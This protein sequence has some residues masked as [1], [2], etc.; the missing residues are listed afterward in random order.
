MKNKIE[1]ETDAV[2]SD[3]QRLQKPLVADMIELNREKKL[4]EIRCFDL[5]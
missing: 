4:S 2:I 1:S 3:L 5:L